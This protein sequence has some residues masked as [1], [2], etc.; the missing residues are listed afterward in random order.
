[1]NAKL[2]PSPTDSSSLRGVRIVAPTGSLRQ[3]F[4]LS[5]V[6]AAIE[7]HRPVL[8]VN[9]NPLRDPYAGAVLDMG[10]TVL[11]PSG[12]V[13]DPAVAMSPLH[14]LSLADDAATRVADP[15]ATVESLVRLAP[16]KHAEHALLIVEGCQALVARGHPALRAL[17]AAALTRGCEFVVVGSQASDTECIADLCGAPVKLPSKYDLRSSYVNPDWLLASRSWTPPAAA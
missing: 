10:G 11:T 13:G 16:R 15:V 1:M 3:Q 2:H 8:L 7:A 5:R 12:P 17:T 14:Y 6:A 4:V 9:L